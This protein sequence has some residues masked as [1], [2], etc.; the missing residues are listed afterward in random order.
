MFEGIP[1]YIHTPSACLLP[2]RPFTSLHVYS[3][4]IS[5]GVFNRAEAIAGQQDIN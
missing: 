2:T 1:K 5:D 3:L 4:G